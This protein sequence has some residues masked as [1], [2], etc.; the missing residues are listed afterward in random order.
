MPNVFNLPTKEQIDKIIDKKAFRDKDIVEENGFNLSGGE[1]QKIILA[2]ALLNDF[3]YLILDETLS[4]VG[5]KE[6]EIILNNIIKKYKDKTIIYITHKKN[7]E[8]LFDEKVY[9]ERNANEL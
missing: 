3:N 7:A 6:E 5:Q 9:L 4:E 2:R 1:R 8:N